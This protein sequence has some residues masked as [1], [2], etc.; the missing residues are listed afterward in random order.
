MRLTGH[1][2]ARLSEAIPLL[3]AGCPRSTAAR[4][5]GLRASFIDEVYAAASEAGATASLVRLR[6]EIDKAEALFEKRMVD[7]FV[8]QFGKSHKAIVDYVQTFRR[9]DQQAPAVRLR[10]EV[11]DGSV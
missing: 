8:G 10:I 9:D 4:L 11:V 3:A 7:A 2:K 1:E 5:V 6:T